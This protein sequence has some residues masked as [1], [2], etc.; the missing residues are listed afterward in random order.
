M[1]VNIILSWSQDSE[2][3]I[4]KFGRQYIKVFRGPIDGAPERLINLLQASAIMCGVTWIALFGPIQ[5]ALRT[6]SGHWGKIPGSRICA[7]ARRYALVSRV[8]SAVSA[9]ATAKQ[10]TREMLPGALLA[11][12]R[13]I[14]AA[15]VLVLKCHRMR[16]TVPRRSHRVAKLRNH[17]GLVVAALRQAEEGL[18][19]GN[20]EVALKTLA[21][22]LLKIGDRHAQGRIG[23]LLDEREL[24][25]LEPVKD[26]EPI[27]IAATTVLVA[28]TL[29]IATLVGLP[30]AAVGYL[31]P[32]VIVLATIIV[33]GRRASLTLNH[34]GQNN[35]GGG[36]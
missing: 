33:Y 10:A 29:V 34:W 4:A 32:A 15:S 3:F 12:S 21:E 28:A 13:E 14:E 7:L 2:S 17:A 26:R 11:V 35:N 31:V 20:H 19:H 18:D 9:C 23:E 8:V 24:E 1:D 36:P 6:R 27:R 22:M 16:G 5:M 25:N 30:D